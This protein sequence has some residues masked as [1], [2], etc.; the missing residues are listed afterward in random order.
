[1]NRIKGIR[2]VKDIA[3]TI[4]SGVFVAGTVGNEAEIALAATAAP[5]KTAMRMSSTLNNRLRAD[6][7]F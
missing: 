4:E 3:I 1:M 5:Y 7:G 2:D 6:E